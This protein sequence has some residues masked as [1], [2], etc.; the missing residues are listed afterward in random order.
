MS[1]QR[2]PQ[3]LSYWVSSATSSSEIKIRVVLKLW[4]R[5]SFDIPSPNPCKLATWAGVLIYLLWE[6]SLLT[7]KAALSSHH[8]CLQA[9][10]RSCSL[11][12]WPAQTPDVITQRWWQN[13]K[14]V[15][16]CSCKASIL[17]SPA[18]WWLSHR[19]G[20]G[21][22][23]L[24]ALPEGKALILLLHRTSCSL[25]RTIM[26][27]SAISSYLPW[28][29]IHSLRENK[30]FLSQ[31]FFCH[32]IL[33]W[34]TPTGLLCAF[35]C[36]WDEPCMACL[37]VLYHAVSNSRASAPQVMDLIEKSF[38]FSLYKGIWV[39]SSSRK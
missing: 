15:L 10:S 11:H 18:F 39:H 31:G 6:E 19:E 26:M 12:A 23:A 34:K 28:A 17:S 20:L 21:A 32:K 4:L 14:H 27:L 8:R 33:R 25:A 1:S 24:S 13:N 2:V 5:V 9:C 16:T 37:S 29:W 35:C 30:N 36:H 3:A 38:S 7:H 22:W